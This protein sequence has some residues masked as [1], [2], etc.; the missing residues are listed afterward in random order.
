MNAG[1]AVCFATGFREAKDSIGAQLQQ[2]LLEVSRD[3]PLLGPNCYGLLNYIQGAM[4]WPDQQGG[5]QVERGVAI[6]TMSSNVAFHLN[7][8]R[9]GLPVAY[10]LSL[11]NKLKFDLHDA[12][13]IF[14]ELIQNQ[15]VTF[16]C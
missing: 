16:C 1:G 6:I 7:M 12:I 10:V 8:Q 13:R 3:M 11:G 9:Q 4:L 15:S 5:R 14:S 2:K